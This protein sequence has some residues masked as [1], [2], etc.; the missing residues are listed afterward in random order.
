M[1]FNE[2][3]RELRAHGVDGP[4]AY[5]FTLLYERL[6][7]TENQLTLCAKVVQQMATSMEGFVQLNEVQQRE[8][9]K[10]I[11]GGRPD[12]IEVASVATEPEDD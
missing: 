4:P 12:G 9:R 2:F 11:R 3:Q 8:V 6:I 5:F 10:F 1:T 7:E